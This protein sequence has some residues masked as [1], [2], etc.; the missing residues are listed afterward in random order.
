[1][2]GAGGPEGTGCHRVEE[3]WVQEGRY[4]LAAEVRAGEFNELQSLFFSQ[5]GRRRGSIW[6]IEPIVRADHRITKEAIDIS[7]GC[8]L[9]VV[10]V[11]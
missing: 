7:Q 10:E 1:M 8:L 11:D 4:G 5:R 3:L 2:I 9:G 6:F